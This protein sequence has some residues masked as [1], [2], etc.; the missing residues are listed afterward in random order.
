MIFKS[1]T[2]IITLYFISSII[3]ADNFDDQRGMTITWY[4][5]I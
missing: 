3:S 1:Q 4:R 5:D 2:T